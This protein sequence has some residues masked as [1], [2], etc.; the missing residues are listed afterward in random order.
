MR[1]SLSKKPAHTASWPL[2]VFSLCFAAKDKGMA[3][4]FATDFV[5]GLGAAEDKDK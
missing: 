2:P 5:A 3:A 1:E 4:V